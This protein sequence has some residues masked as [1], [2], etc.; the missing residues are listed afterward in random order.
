MYDKQNYKNKNLGSTA[1]DTNEKR[2]QKNLNQ[3]LQNQG[4]R[5]PTTQ[6]ISD[7]HEKQNFQNYSNDV[8]PIELMAKKQYFI[9]INCNSLSIK[10][11]QVRSTLYQQSN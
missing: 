8:V 5:K 10:S 1:T 11:T 3:V 4:G 9:A 7:L 6:M 2:A